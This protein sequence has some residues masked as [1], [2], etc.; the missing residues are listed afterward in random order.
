MSSELPSLIFSFLWSSA[1]QSILACTSNNFTLRLIQRNKSYYNI[2]RRMSINHLL[3]SNKFL[4]T[5]LAIVTMDGQCHH[6]VACLEQ[7][8]DAYVLIWQLLIKFAI[9][10]ASQFLPP[11]GL[12]I[13]YSITSQ[14]A[15]NK[16][17]P[18]LS[19]I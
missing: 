19:I 4:L 18:M 15:L 13:L 12:N 17:A 14:F 10:L 9:L 2:R 3:I 16:E 8:E 5:K 7:Q 1:F 6:W 11:H